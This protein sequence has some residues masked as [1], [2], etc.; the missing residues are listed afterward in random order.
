M[1]VTL[2]SSNNIAQIVLVHDMSL[3]RDCVTGSFGP[4]FDDSDAD[5]ILRSDFTAPGSRES[6]VVPT[7]FLVH[8]LFLI[9][10]SSVFKSVLSKS[11]APNSKK[12]NYSAQNAEALKHGISIKRGNLLIFCLSE[13]RDT[14]HRL[15]TAIYPIDIVL[16]QTFETMLKTFAAARKYGMPSVLALFR[17]YCG[18]VAP[19]VTTENAFRAYVFASNEGLK[20]EALEAAR[21]TLSLP[22]SFETYGP[23]LSNASG[24]ALRALW[25]HRELAFKTIRRGVER[26]LKEVG[27]LRDWKLELP[28]DKSCC[29]VPAPRMLEQFL[30]FTEKIPQNFSTMNIS[31]FLDTMSPQGGFHCTCKRPQRLDNLRLFECLERCVQSG[32]DQASPLSLVQEGCDQCTFQMHN[33]LLPLFDGLG[34]ASDAQPSTSQPR[35]FGPPFD[36]GD[37]DVTIRSCDRVDFH[38]HKA[39]LGL[40]SAAFEDMFT[41]PSPHGQEPVKQVI[42]LTETS[43]TLRHLLSVIYPIKRIVPDTLEG[44]LSLLSACQKYQ[45]DSTA[46]RIRALIKA[47]TQPFTA[48]NSFR[49]YGIASRYCLE[50]EALSAARLT[51]ERTMNFDTCGEDLRYISGADLSRLFVYRNECTRVAKDCIN[52][53]I[54]HKTPPLSSSTCSRPVKIGKYDT[55]ELQSV[56]RWWHGHFLSRI[57]EQPSPKTVC[58]RQAFEQAIAPHRDTSWCSSCLPPDET[59]IDN[60]ICAAIEAKL[61]TVIEQVSPDHVFGRTP[62]L[63]C[64]AG[65][66]QCSNIVG[67][68]CPFS[69]SMNSGQPDLE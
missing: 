42:D 37:S 36:R 54:D 55:K 20:E 67:F 14:V 69:S 53:M 10:A 41:L 63:M 43:K 7:D 9:K 34:E 2:L 8:K 18:R 30:L 49:A 65:S 27:D 46:T 5:I 25:K 45:M 66:S 52:K 32:L 44:A 28:G 4:P 61:S 17:A 24:P 21:L 68:E 39:I 56:P 6:H 12:N 60:T 31:N 48:T 19:I 51:L 64:A 23:S 13:D 47:G 3:P 33:S 1:F 38:V 22:Q 50:E 29:S 57:A 16:P 40:A 35:N 11:P 26:C 58:D 62:E 15:L 59:R